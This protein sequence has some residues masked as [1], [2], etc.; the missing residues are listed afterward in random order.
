MRRTKLPGWFAVASS[1]AV[2]GR[3]F[4][5]FSLSPALPAFT[6]RRYR[7]EETDLQA[8]GDAALGVPT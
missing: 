4:G 7:I 2:V 5:D 6:L 1:R 8:S 3:A